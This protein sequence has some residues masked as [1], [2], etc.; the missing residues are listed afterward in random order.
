[1]TRVQRQVYDALAGFLHA[2][3]YSP[4]LAELGRLVGIRSI[5]TVH[6]HVQKLIAQGKV[7][8]GKD[9]ARSLELVPV[10]NDRCPTCGQ[11]IEPSS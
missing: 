9:F 8:K 10:R 3:N 2:H 7:R 4:S 11:M 1:M 5:S 6:V